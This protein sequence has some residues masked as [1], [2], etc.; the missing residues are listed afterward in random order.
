MPL[1]FS[2]VAD[3]SLLPFATPGSVRIPFGD[4]NLSDPINIGTIFET[5]F[6][7]GQTSSPQVRVSTN[8]DIYFQSAGGQSNVYLDPLNLDQDTRSFPA[9]VT[10]PGIWVDFNTA[11]DSVVMT[12]NAVGQY[13][14][15]TDM[16]STYQIEFMDLGNGSSE[17][18]FRFN[19]TSLPRLA[20]GWLFG[21]SL[22]F[23]GLIPVSDW[24]TTLGNTGVAGVWQFRVDAGTLLSED[25]V[26]ADRLL[27][28]T[29]GADSLTGW[30]GND[31][32]NGLDGDDTLMGE[33]GQDTIFGG[34]GHNSLYGGGGHDWITAGAGN[35][36]ILAGDGS[37]LV[38]A[39]A[40][41][42]SIDAGH[43]DDSV[44]GAAG[45]DTILGGS[46]GDS[47]FGGSGA[48]SLLGGDGRDRIDG[49]DGDDLIAAGTGN[50][51][52][53]GGDGDDF[54]FGSQGQDVATGGAG[55][56][57]FF[58]SRADGDGMIVTDYN[59]DEGDLLLLS[60]LDY[61]A[62][63]LR[64]SATRSY[65]L[66]GQWVLDGPVLIE[67]VEPSGGPNRVLFTL[68]NAAVLDQ[69]VIRLAGE[70]RADYTFDLLA[71]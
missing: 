31:H 34:E 29:A 42:D 22:A 55:A 20:A 1:P 59:A 25:V 38:G 63:D 4:D 57:R 60:D 46:G 70:G 44:Y 64:I 53:L 68:E 65:D 13:P 30:L 8:G 61:A 5:G 28:G 54:L 9:G 7:L 40:G 43:G 24:D 51:T 39:G 69:L 41:D 62:A 15:M 16:P 27:R 52:L 21:Y 17:I 10:N 71:A 45:N 37:D 32:L 67:A 49:G 3:N 33:V 14:R 36:S 23:S 47:L 56:D 12:W 18:I 66:T 58:V 2:A 35:D 11:R 26:V 50:D 6:R 19:E 48:D